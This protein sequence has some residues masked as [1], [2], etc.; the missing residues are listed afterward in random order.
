M[1]TRSH[2]TPTTTIKTGKPICRLMCLPTTPLE[3]LSFTFSTLETV[4]RDHLKYEI[5]G[6]LGSEFNYKTSEKLQ[7]LRITDSPWPLDCCSELPKIDF[8][9]EC[10]SK[11]TVF[12]EPVFQPTISIV[13]ESE[14]EIVSDSDEGTTMRPRKTRSQLRIL[15]DEF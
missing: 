2:R 3:E 8:F 11:K 5:L 6:L 10:F 15:H 7:S 13:S 4:A 14:P 12:V 9:G 1:Q